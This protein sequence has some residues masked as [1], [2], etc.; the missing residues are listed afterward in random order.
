LKNPRPQ[1]QA[2]LAESGG[3]GMENGIKK[4]DESAKKKKKVE[5]GVCQHLC[6]AFAWQ[7]QC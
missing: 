2:A 1:L 4:K 6:I 5:K 3:V 7:L